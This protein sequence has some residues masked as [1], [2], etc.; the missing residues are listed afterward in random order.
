M[1]LEHLT[2][3]ASV[4]TIGDLAF[5]ICYCGER[6]INGGKNVIWS[7]DNGTLVL[8]KNPAAQSDADFLLSDVTWRDIEKNIKRIKI[9]CGVIP[10]KN[11]FEWLWRFGRDVQIKF[12]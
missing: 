6:T 2:I 11:F 4:T 1:K 10:D 7:L 8:K 5:I 9:E 12:L 3:P